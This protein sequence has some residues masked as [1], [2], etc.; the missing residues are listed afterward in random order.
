MNKINKEEI[1][2]LLKDLAANV[3]YVLISEPFDTP[4]NET[5]IERLPDSKQLFWSVPASVL[6]DKENMKFRIQVN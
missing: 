2:Q 4:F 1:E 5:S 6:D 3:G